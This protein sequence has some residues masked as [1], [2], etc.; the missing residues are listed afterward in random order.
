MLD[1]SLVNQAI[2]N[3]DAGYLA[4]LIKNGTLSLKDGKLVADS[5]TR[6]QSYAFW[7]RR[8][9]IRKILLNS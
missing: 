8:Q 3:N 4:S 9:L 2:E 5:A 7:D 1:P 6:D